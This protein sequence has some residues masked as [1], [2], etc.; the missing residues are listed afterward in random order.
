MDRLTK[1]LFAAIGFAVVQT[2]TTVAFFQNAIGAASMI[3]CWAHEIRR[4]P[5]L[6]V[7]EWLDARGWEGDRSMELLLQAV[8]DAEKREARL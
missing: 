3:F 1:L 2:V 7:Q 5:V 4:A 8:K 6:I